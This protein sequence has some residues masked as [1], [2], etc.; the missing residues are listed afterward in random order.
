VD[1][2]AE[3][4]KV[5]SAAVSL[6]GKRVTVTRLRAK[7]GA[8]AFTGDYRWEPAAV[9]PH[10]FHITIPE[11]DA[12][13]LQ[14]ILEPALA[15]NSGFFARTLRLGD[16]PVPDWLAAR[17][18]DGTVTIGS[19]KFGDAEVRVDAARMLWDAA[20]VRFLA[21]GAHIDDSVL[22]GDLTV[23]LTRRAPHYRFEG[24]LF[25]VDYKDG[26]LDFEGNLDADGLGADILASARAEGH[27]HGR[28]IAFSPDAEFR[29]AAACFEVTE[30]NG[31]ERWK[32]SS[33]EVTQGSDTYTGA[34]ATQSDGRLVLDL[35]SR[36]RQVRYSTL[37]AA[38]P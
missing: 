38:A 11:A 2:L 12:A 5:Q 6:N 19:L 33:V 28:S 8:I 26:I 14:R 4:V 1:G 13:E 22:A 3:A 25:G 23:D 35:L 10:K 15:R 9:R 29:T 37:L 21:V 31:G 24:K 36:G 20:Q 30:Q 27:V 17:R 18:A 34:G 16:A 32:L 7:V